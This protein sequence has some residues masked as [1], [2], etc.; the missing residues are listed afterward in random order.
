MFT[1][2]GKKI[3]GL[4]K[5]ITWIFIALSIIVGITMFRFSV[6]TGILVILIGSALAWVGSFILYGLGELIDSN[7]EIKKDMDT[8]LM[9]MNTIDR[10][11]VEIRLQLDKKKAAEPKPTVVSSDNMIYC[12]KCG[13]ANIPTMTYCSSCGSKLN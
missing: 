11:I 6:W 9:S 8:V 3:K 5:V 4:A 10:D 2:I 1:N 12:S 7:S 13:R